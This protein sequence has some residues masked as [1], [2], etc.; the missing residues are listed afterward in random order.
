MNRPAEAAA[1]FTAMY[2]A[3]PTGVW[4]A[5]GRVNFMGEHTDYNLGFVFPLAID[6]RAHVAATLRADGVLRLATTGPGEPV[7][8]PLDQ[9]RPGRPVGWSRYLAGVLWA[10]GLRGVDLSG[11][12]LLLDSDVPW[13]AGLSSSAAIAC[14]AALAVNDLSGANL[15]AEDLVLLCQQA[16]NEF[17][18]V[19]T[20]I[21]DQSAALLATAG[22]GLF[23][24]CRS[25]ESRAVPLDLAGQE[26]CLLVIDTKVSH[27]H[28]S[29]G[30]ADRRGDCERA[31]RQ[32]GLGSLRE[33]GL[34]DLVLAAGD[35]DHRAYRRARHV[36]SENARVLSVV[37]HLDSGKPVARLGP[38]L[39][40]S[41]ESL[42]DD[43]EVSCPE[44]DLAVEAA[45]AAG[46]EGARMTGGGFGGS[47]IALV[48]RSAAGRVS[49]G[50]RR[51]FSRSGYA[52][53]EVYAVEAGAAGRRES[54]SGSA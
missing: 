52:D 53:P 5:P 47:A 31:A 19:Q 9:L 4:S 46:A 44:L 51:A 16:E 33:I 38:V 24:D 26:M 12:D 48:R 29:S 50:V 37:G 25:R 1:R 11:M 42:R 40:S 30:Y 15:P 32:L 45:V 17:A 43:F 23:L 22:N 8:V 27:S 35:L 41:H 2:G 34:P 10:F 7:T 21:L 20:G 13:G 6:R 49:D 28:D 39:A 3:A 36:V 14:A 18:G 54:W